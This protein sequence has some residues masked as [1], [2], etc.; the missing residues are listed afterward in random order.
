MASDPVAIRGMWESAFQEK[1]ELIRTIDPDKLERATE[2]HG[3]TVRNL[4]THVAIGSDSPLG[5]AAPKLARGKP[6]LPVPVPTWLFTKIGDLDNARQAKK[7]ARSAPEELVG[8]MDES[9]AKAAKA[10]DAVPAT[11]WDSPAFI[12]TMGKLSLAEF[13]QRMVEHD[14]EHAEVLKRALA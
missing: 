10:L 6:L 3:W 2:N 8:L 7:R 13:V 9:H 12:P 5:M 4:A 14:Q 1:R 11:G